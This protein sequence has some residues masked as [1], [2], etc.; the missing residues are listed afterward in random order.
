M[1]QIW[2]IIYTFEA[3]L[4]PTIAIVLYHLKAIGI[5][6]IKFLAE[7]ASPFY[8]LGVYLAVTGRTQKSE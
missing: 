7:L 2:K 6:D 4:P 1:K 8:L 3:I 5:A